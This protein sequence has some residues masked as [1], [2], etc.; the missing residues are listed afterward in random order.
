MLFTLVACG[1]PPAY[2]SKNDI[3][4]TTVVWVNE[5]KGIAWTDSNGNVMSPGDGMFISVGADI[6]NIS[7]TDQPCFLGSV[8]LGDRLGITGANPEAI[9]TTTDGIQYPAYFIDKQVN[10]Y[11]Q[12]SFDTTDTN[13]CHPKDTVRLDFVFVV[14]ENAKASTFTYKDLPSIDVTGLSK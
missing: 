12:I 8:Q 7:S 6:L 2:Q 3:W 10:G 14:P 11:G 5:T 1:A 9:L 13:G 4:Q